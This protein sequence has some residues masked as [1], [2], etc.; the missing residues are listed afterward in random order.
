[1]IIDVVEKLIREKIHPRNYYEILNNLD[2]YISKDENI[3]NEVLE[4]LDKYKMDNDLLCVIE[5]FLQL[6]QKEIIVE[7]N[8]EVINKKIIE[9]WI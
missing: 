8:F 6:K 7:N 9:D 4:C 2:E 1:M 3:I 5:L